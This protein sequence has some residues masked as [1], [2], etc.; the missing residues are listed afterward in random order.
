[1]KRIPTA[2]HGVFDY[3]CATMLYALPRILHWRAEISLL[4]TVVAGAMVIYSLLT[5][6]EWGT[7]RRI[8]MRTH[9]ILDALAGIALCVGPLLLSESMAIKVIPFGFG[10]VMLVLASFTPPA[11]DVPAQIAEPAPL[12]ALGRD[13][14][15]DRAA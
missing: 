13:E 12:S 1:M 5:R 4:T 2:V 7:L 3:L 10:L 9:L 14:P 11:T 6:Y 15:L 8:S